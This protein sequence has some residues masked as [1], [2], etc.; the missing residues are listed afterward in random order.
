M[1]VKFLDPKV[2]TKLS[3]HFSS[4]EFRCKC[5]NCL[6]HEF[7]LNSDLVD[8]LEKLYAKLDCSKIYVNS[9]YRCHNHD[10][11]VGGSGYGQHCEGNAADIKCYRG[12]TI[13][14]TKEVACAAQDIGFGG[15]ANIDY[16]YT[17]IHVDV[18]TSNFWKGDEAV[19]GG[20]S[21]TVTNDFYSYYGIK[22]P[23][24]ALSNIV[25]SMQIAIG[26]TADGIVGPNTIEVLSSGKYN[27]S[28]EVVTYM[29]TMLN[30]KG[31]NC[32]TADGIIGNNT[33]DAITKLKKTTGS[34][35]SLTR[36]DWEYLV[37]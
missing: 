35:K 15:I 22:K 27:D 24:S 29:Q 31:I 25:K 28:K 34:I 10:R 3:P 17:A 23:T 16:S 21:G 14:S 32:G 1:G 19:K 36:E 33:I 2:N 6:A 30:S 5:V 26:V 11:A 18:R 12:D 20:T 7:K 4:N 37:K 8:K 9:G 13:I